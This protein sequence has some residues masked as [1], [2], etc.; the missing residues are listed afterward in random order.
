MR[1]RTDAHQALIEKI[2]K[3]KCWNLDH[4]KVEG[5]CVLK[6]QV[7]VAVVYTHVVCERKSQVAAAAAA[8]AG[9]AVAV[10]L[11]QTT[12]MLEPVVSHKSLVN[13]DIPQHNPGL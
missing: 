4:K 1:E 10:V 11:N 6:S 3:C 8:A 5:N 13:D 9:I 12:S 7:V 2:I